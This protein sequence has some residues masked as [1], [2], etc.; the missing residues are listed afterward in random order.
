ML[1]IKAIENRAAL[2]AFAPQWQVLADLAAE[3][4]PFFAPWNIL[5]AL[6]LAAARQEQP[7]TCLFAYDG[8]Q[9]VGFV[10]LIM[11][12]TYARL[13]VRFWQ[14]WVHDQS[15]FGAPLI[16]PGYEGD[17]LA[18]VLAWADQS[19]TGSFLQL[20]KLDATGPFAKAVAAQTGRVNYL[21]QKI[22]RA[23][24]HSDLPYTTYIEQ[25]IRGKKRKEMRRLDNRLAE[26]GSVRFEQLSSG[27]QLEAWAE[28]FLQLE[29]ASWKGGEGSSLKA[30]AATRAYFHGI[31]QGAG[32]QD[33]LMLQRL[34][35][36]DTPLAMLVNFV[37]KGHAFS[38]K[39]AFD[40]GYSRFSP[41]VMI[42]L[43]FTKAVLG[44]ENIAF[45]D[46][47]AGEN[48]PMINHLWA[49]RR[50]IS[51][52]NISLKRGFGALVLR[53]CRRLEEFGAKRRGS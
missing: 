2:P 25:N 5:P 8:E 10:P 47:C 41:G 49:E 23:C 36:D 34:M 16:A 29:D 21:G 42:E 18:A 51:M 6:D 3:P 28:M 53:V 22:E 38:Y 24:L 45:V 20:Q 32:A 27:D 43:N 48:H 50:V 9:M 33:S 14:N 13:P 40:E 37:T 35:L 4:N 30:T 7:P 1:T 26:E 44:D 19:G 15:F 17:F 11:A 52:H 12:K 46:S 39:I 31:L